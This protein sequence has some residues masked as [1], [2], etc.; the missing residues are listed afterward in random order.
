MGEPTTKTTK[1]DYLSHRF[2]IL[3]ENRR[4]GNYITSNHASHAQTQHRYIR[5]CLI[6]A[7]YV[8]LSLYALCR[9]QKLCLSANIALFCTVLLSDEYTYDAR[10]ILITDLLK[11]FR[12]FDKIFCFLMLC[13][14][15][16]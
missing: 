5:F 16:L 11:R 14:L 4:D 9:M 8:F 12:D 7:S 13:S 2:V 10:T 15:A 3:N 1:L 6:N